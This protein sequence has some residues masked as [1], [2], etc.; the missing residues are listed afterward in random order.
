MDTSFH[1][2]TSLYS[3]NRQRDRCK[4]VRFDVDDYTSVEKMLD[5]GTFASDDKIE[6]T[7]A[8]IKNFLRGGIIGQD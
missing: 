8:A 7:A 1:P 2:A 4:I 3:F 6:I 5:T